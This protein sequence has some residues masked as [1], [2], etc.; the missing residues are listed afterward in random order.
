MNSRL[1]FSLL[2][3][4]LLTQALSLWTAHY[5]IGEE[6]QATILNENSQDIINSFG[7]FGYILAFTLVLLLIIKFLKK[8]SSHLI[9]ILESLGT[10]AGAT[11]SLTAIYPSD[12]MALAAI[13]LVIA[14]W[15][16]KAS[17]PLRNTATLLACAGAGALIGVSL[18]PIPIA[19]FVALLA[20]YDFIAVFKTKHMLTLAKA[21]T[22]QNMA[23]SYRLNSAE[24]EGI[25][26][27][28]GD[29]VV[30]AAFA[31][32]LLKNYSMLAAPFNLIP[33]LLIL[34]ASLAGLLFTVHAAAQKKGEG[35]PAIPLQAALMLT[36]FMAI[37]AFY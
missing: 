26:L 11:L 8:W 5:L 6:L 28:S 19:V 18:G 4:F 7:L 23:F 30:P 21:V 29:L 10:W 1:T 22:A 13:A 37:T 32:S 34:A 16:W 3:F 2:A 35:L 17:V 9:R 15:K 20:I 33:S 36:T 31:A 12:L 25:E 14:R 27:G 24:K